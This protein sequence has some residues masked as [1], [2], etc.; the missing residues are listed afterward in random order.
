MIRYDDK[1]LVPVVVQDAETGQVL[2]MAYANAQAVEKTRD[3]GWAHFWSRSRQTLWKK[4]E[5]SGNALKVL[6]VLG[7]CDEDALLYQVRPQGPTC[8]TGN[9]SCFH[10]PQ[11]ED[12]TTCV[13]YDVVHQLGEVIAQ[14]R[15]ERP[16]GSY[17]AS[18]FAQGEDAVLKKVGEEAVEVVL[19]AKARDRT[20]LAYEGA[21]LLFHTLLALEYAGV[22][23]S[24]ILDELAARR[25]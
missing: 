13:T 4:G 23:W 18:L 3:T 17:V 5:T 14:R 22:S 15:I 25:R 9:N 11:W 12:E 16:E 2:M 6:A 8:H 19:A 10:H 20:A 21:D 24:D 7:D 1:G